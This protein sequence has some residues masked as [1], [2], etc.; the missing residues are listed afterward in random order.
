MHERLSE[1]S[2]N[3]VT[4][5]VWWSATG[6]T[7][8]KTFPL[9]QLL[10]TQEIHKWVC[11]Q[12]NYWAYWALKRN[13]SAAIRGFVWKENRG[14]MTFLTLLSLHSLC[15]PW[16]LCGLL[17]V[18][19][20]QRTGKAVDEL[21]WNLLLEVGWGPSQDISSSIGEAAQKPCLVVSCYLRMDSVKWCII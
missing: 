5:S 13:W 12:W 7:S 11:N 15:P 14:N 1:F 8:E 20:C 18:F 9:V 17:V 16:R 21:A 10:E 4:C 3:T 19:V 2:R 6:S